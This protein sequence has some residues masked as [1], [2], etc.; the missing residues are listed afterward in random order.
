MNE[1]SNLYWDIDM[2]FGS[3]KE[4]EYCDQTAID[5]RRYDYDE[6]FREAR[7]LYELQT[8]LLENK[9]CRFDMYLRF[10]E[11]PGAGNGAFD[12]VKHWSLVGGFDSADKFFKNQA[13]SFEALY[14]H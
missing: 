2:C 6:A 7:R 3:S 13:H 9:L 4:A 11:S 8:G 14:L 10:D 5:V 1:H 12:I